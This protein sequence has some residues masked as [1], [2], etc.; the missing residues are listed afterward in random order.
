MVKYV[1]DYESDIKPRVLHFHTSARTLKKKASSEFEKFYCLGK[2]RERGR[3]IT[4]VPY[5]FMRYVD[6][7]ERL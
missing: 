7:K 5:F 2:E 4:S 6:R 1:L 3:Q